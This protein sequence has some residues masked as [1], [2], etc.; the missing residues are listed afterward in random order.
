MHLLKKL[1][2]AA[3]HFILRTVPNFD[4]KAKA[5]FLAFLNTD[6]NQR[7]HTKL[8]VLFRFAIIATALVFVINLLSLGRSTFGEWGD[9]FGG[10]L[11]PILTFLTFM[12]LLITIAIQSAELKE[13]RKEAARSASAL[14]NQ[15]L[16]ITKQ[17]FENTFFQMLSLHNQIVE[18]IDLYNKD[19]KRTSKGRDCFT[20]FVNRLNKHY[21]LN[22]RGDFSHSENAL[23]LKSYGQFW[24]KA[25]TELGHYFRYLFNITSFVKN[26]NPSNS[27]FYMR[28][29]R[30]QLSYQEMI[31][32]FYN[33]QTP[34]G[35]KF[36]DLVEEFTLLDNLPKSALFHPSHKELIAPTA[37]EK[38]T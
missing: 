15:N 36:K 32:L 11:N 18:S 24:E 2:M 34:Q 14:E 8:Y 35:K 16:A 37:F 22:K 38:V 21:Q 23:I 9:F 1:Q 5:A 12:G 17:N 29:L 26:S 25:E 33:C 28:L 6:S 13:A 7:A 20:T 3:Q 19:T 31:V 4:K 10:V 30:A 27:E